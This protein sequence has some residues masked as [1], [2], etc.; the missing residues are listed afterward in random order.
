MSKTAIAKITGVPRTTLY[1]FMNTRWLRPS[2][3]VYA[4][5]P[6]GSWCQA[7]ARTQPRGGGVQ[8]MGSGLSGLSFIP[9]DCVAL[10]A[11][12]QL[13][14]RPSIGHVRLLLIGLVREGDAVLEE[15]AC[16]SAFREDGSPRP[17]GRVARLYFPLGEAG[18]GA[19]PGSDD[20]P[21]VVVGPVFSVCVLRGRGFVHRPQLHASIMSDR[22][23]S[24]GGG[25][26]AQCATSRRRR[27]RR[28]G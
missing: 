25:D 12:P 4:C 28:S 5:G 23:A 10:R 6:S 15:E 26:G 19:C 11:R 14:P 27:S 16:V 18:S 17:R 7:R 21:L 13:R 2:V 22:L 3:E 1:S 9:N 8:V 24:S 20:P